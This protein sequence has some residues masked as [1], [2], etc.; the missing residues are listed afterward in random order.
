MPV[1][2]HQAERRP[3]PDGEKP[4]PRRAG[5]LQVAKTM[6]FGLLMIGKRS[7]WEQGGEGARMTPGQI[8]AGAII[9]GI[10]LIAV[11]LAI[12]RVALRLAG[13]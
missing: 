13:V 5:V 6:F 4:P 12:V 7:T 10:V 3:E 8:V 11:L 1:K 9:G 2:L